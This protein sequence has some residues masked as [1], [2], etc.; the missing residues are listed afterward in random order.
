MGHLLR[1]LQYAWRGL[2]RA[3]MFSLVALASIA[4]GIGANTAIFSLVDAAMLKPLPYATPGALV[5][6]WESSGETPRM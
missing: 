6:V 4:L 1:D 5:S 2:I 3:P